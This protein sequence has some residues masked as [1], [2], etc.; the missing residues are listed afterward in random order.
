M[1]RP[2]GV[3]PVV[4]AADGSATSSGEDRSPE[5]DCEDRWLVG[6]DDLFSP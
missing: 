1:A 4:L 3:A 6:V 2:S 5:V